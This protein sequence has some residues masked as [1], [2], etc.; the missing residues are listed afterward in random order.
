VAAWLVDHT[1][2]AVEERADGLLVACAADPSGAARLSADLAARFGPAVHATV[3][4]TPGVAWDRRWREGLR[5]RRLGRLTLTPSWVEP[6]REAGAV[7]VLDPEMAFGSGEHG[8]TR[9]ALL[10]LDRCLTTGAT[11]LDLG[12]GSG[13]LAIAAVKLGARHAIGIERDPEAV[14]VAERNAKRNGVARS[15]VFLEGDAAVLAPL[16]GPADLV[17][18]NI[19]RETNV[20][21]L[22]VVRDALRTGGTAIFAG[23]ETPE[24]DL[25]LP[26]LRGTGC[27]VRDSVTEDGWWAVAVRRQ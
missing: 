10:L 26:H 22:P 9:S 11:V 19:L 12:S 20:A 13:I 4:E 27:A 7:V 25:F 16:A 14:A 8:S 24:A 6:S 1:G 17:I 2:H 23:M 5:S 21:L 3:R 18:A 15:V